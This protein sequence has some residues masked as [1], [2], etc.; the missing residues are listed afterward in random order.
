MLFFG[1]FGVFLERRVQPLRRSWLHG[2]HGDGKLAGAAAARLP[3]AAGRAGSARASAASRSGGAGGGS[4]RH[5]P[6]HHLHP[7]K[8]RS[9]QALPPTQPADGGA[10]LHRRV[11]RVCV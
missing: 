10:E 8:L 6:R 1:A 11:L 4:G 3:G 9:G 5:R 2:G 7:F